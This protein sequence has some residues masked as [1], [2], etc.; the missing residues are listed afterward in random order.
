[1]E[2]LVLHSRSPEELREQLRNIAAQRETPRLALAFASDRILSEAT[3]R[4]YQEFGINVF[5]GCSS[6]EIAVDRVYKGSIV[7]L[8]LDLPEEYYRLRV[9]YARERPGDGG[10]RELG[11]SIARFAA[12]SF[13]NPVLLLLVGGGGLSIHSEELL[14]GILEERPGTAVFGGLSSSLGAF[15]RPP[16][17]SVTRIIPAGVSVLA[18][19]GE[20]IDVRGVAVSGWREVGAAKRITRSEGNKVYEIEGEAATDFYERYFALRGDSSETRRNNFDPDLLAASEYPLLL[21]REDGSEVIRA[22][23]QLDPVEKAVSYGGD[24]P[25]GS[26]VRFCSP[27]V[28]ET[29]QHTIDEMQGFRDEQRN[30]KADA[31][32]LFNCAV[33]SRAYGPYLNHELKLI[34]ELWQAPLAGFNS[35]GEIGQTPGMACD[36]HNTVISTV[37]LRRKDQQQAWSAPHRFTAAQMQSLVEEEIGARSSESLAAE[38]EQLR[39][40][41]RILSHFLRLTSN[42]LEL[43]RQKGEALLRNILP[44][45]IAERLKRGEA[46]IAD[47][48]SEASIL[49]ADLV[50]FTTLSA[51]MSA[52]QLVRVLN[53]LFSRFDEASADLGVE[54][55]KTIGDAYMAVAG[56]PEAAIDHADRCVRLARAMFAALADVNRQFALQLQLRV[57]VNSGA[58]VA[59]VIGKRKFSY[60]LWGDAV[61]LAQRMESHGEAGAIQVSASTYA[62]LQDKDGFVERGPVELKGVGPVRAYLLPLSAPR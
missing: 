40:E 43:E 17:F 13:R 18:L 50:G 47:Q 33:R 32:L 41:K 54:K 52:D 62:A 21:R 49:F 16:I 48:V 28:V 14:R 56:L 4:P 30:L 39:R 24:I 23:L 51:Q 1:M 42:D 36:F 31:V 7:S 19:D 55:I 58:V 45:S 61:N 38:V 15:D 60:D 27:N 25:Q 22:A 6:E 3:L 37:V 57:G 9:F 2:P 53:E 29:I 34:H 8:L 12:D 59:G 10:D 11:R 44:E 26:L 35:W 5:G 20:Q 46:V